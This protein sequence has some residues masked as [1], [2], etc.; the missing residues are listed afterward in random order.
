M[1]GSEPEQHVMHRRRAPGTE[2]SWTCF[3][4]QQSISTCKWHLHT[5]TMEDICTAICWKEKHAFKNPILIYF[6]RAARTER[7]ILRIPC[8]VCSVHA[9]TGYGSRS[10]QLHSSRVNSS[11]QGGVFEAFSSTEAAA[12]PLLW[13][14]NYKGK[15]LR[16]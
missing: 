12:R 3:P 8:M 14:L 13:P 7:L 5:F 11:N 1:K 10:I 9:A 4:R 2:R 16:D 15:L 6:M